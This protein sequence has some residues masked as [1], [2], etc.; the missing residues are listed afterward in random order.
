[1]PERCCYVVREDISTEEAALLE[2]LSIGVHAVQLL[3]PVQGTTIAI[4]G[5]GPIGLSVLIAALEAGAHRAYVTDKL[6]ERLALARR[7]EATWT[8][9]PDLTDVA[10]DVERQ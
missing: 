5:S 4:L 1:M 9:N 6:D 3:A 2:P 8:G 10:G 7:L